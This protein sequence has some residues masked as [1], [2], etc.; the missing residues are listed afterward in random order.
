MT[1]A[2]PTLTRERAPGSMAGRA[3]P[4][5][6]VWLVLVAIGT[7][8]LFVRYQ[9]RS[10]WG[11]DDGNFAHVAERV[12]DGEVLNRDVQDIH[13]GYINLTN[14]GA[15]A[16][17]GRSIVGM[18][19]PLGAL[20]LG[21]AL[22]VFLLLRERGPWTAAAGA[23]GMTA[24]GVIQFVNPT[25]HWY[26]L[27]L[28]VVL[29]AW[30][31][32]R[33]VGSGGRLAGVGFLVMTIF[34]FR[35]LTGV[36]VGIGALC[37][38]LMEAD[39]GSTRGGRLLARTL[40]ATMLL[41]LCWYLARS[42]SLSSWV[43]FGVWPIALLLV[44][45]MLVGA[46]DRV[47]ARMLA[48]LLAGSAA[49][50]APLVLYHV[51]HGSLATWFADVVVAAVSLPTLAFVDDF[52]FAVWM[53]GGAATMASGDLRAT[54]S[55][56]FWVVAPAL[57]LI[58]GVLALRRLAPRARGPWV[59][60]D[61]LPVLAVFYSVV[62]VHYAIPLYLHYT[63]PL[64][65]AA[66]L[67]LASV[68]GVRRLWLA[69]A[70]VA[71]LSVHAIAFNAG[72]PAARFPQQIVRGE[73]QPLVAVPE[74]PKAGILIEPTDAALH[75]ALVR[76]IRAEVP[77]SR[78]IAAIPSNAELYFLAERRNPFRFFNSALG[79]R[80]RQGLEA[81]TRALRRDPP[82]L[83][84]HDTA[85]KYNTAWSDSLMAVVRASHVRD[86]TVER[87]HVYRRRPG[88]VEAR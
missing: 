60:R 65:A 88:M 20:A 14:A 86:G 30:L 76:R 77:P 40:L 84:F 70:L 47:V 8:A 27:F 7:G 66:L 17:F 51:V 5:L 18:R 3:R 29:I 41:G 59:G 2:G 15:M 79:V 34:L 73:R 1:L 22:T 24:L 55:A 16:V 28:T 50:A 12:L 81:A 45:L 78:S 10:W 19:Y 52:S 83:V 64:S 13:A 44:A 74:L 26:C 87:F 49:A 11:P 71:A 6:L 43:L 80:D 57:A 46:A 75:L 25:P 63:L 61:A 53:V 62:S 42:A 35:Q 67:A 31:R 23:L 72:Q 69:P 58:V 68:P 38:L 37:F 32:W 36:L 39:D 56:A 4:S 9:D 85:D 48:A 82:A 21:Q 54:T 33:P